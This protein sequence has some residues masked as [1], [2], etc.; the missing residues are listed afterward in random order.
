MRHWPPSRT[1]GLEEYLCAQ[2]CQSLHLY[3]DFVAR[4]PLVAKCPRWGQSP[5]L[6]QFDGRERP[7]WDLAHRFIAATAP[8]S[9]AWS[10]IEAATPGYF[11]AIAF[12]FHTSFVCNVIDV[13][14]IIVFDLSEFRRN[15]HSMWYAS[16]VF[17]SAAL[18]IF[19]QNFS[20]EMLSIAFAAVWSMR[21]SRCTASVSTTLCTWF[22]VVANGSNGL[23][24]FSDTYHFTVCCDPQNYQ[25]PTIAPVRSFSFCTTPSHCWWARTAYFR[26]FVDRNQSKHRSVSEV[27]RG[28]AAQVDTRPAEG[29][30]EMAA[31]RASFTWRCRNTKRCT[32]RRV[33]RSRE[34]GIKF[35]GTQ[36]LQHWRQT[37]AR[38]ATDDR[39]M[40]TRRWICDEECTVL[41]LRRRNRRAI[42]WW[43]VARQ[44]RL[45]L[46]QCRSQVL[47]ARKEQELMELR[48][49]RVWSWQDSQAETQHD[50][51]FVVRD[52]RSISR[53]F[54]NLYHIPALVNAL[55]GVYGHLSQNFCVRARRIRAAFQEGGNTLRPEI[56]AVVLIWRRLISV[57]SYSFWRQSIFFKAVEGLQ[58]LTWADF[59]SYTVFALCGLS[60]L[61]LYKE[62]NTQPLWKVKGLEQYTSWKVRVPDCVFREKWAKSDTDMFM[63]T[64]MYI[65]TYRCMYMCVYVS[66][67]FCVVSY[68]VVSCVARRCWL[69]GWV[70]CG[71]IDMSL[72]WWSLFLCRC[73]S[74][75][76]VIEK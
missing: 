23:C 17:A 72:S 61:Y 18:F 15:T 56:H 55:T 74:L 73:P 13:A 69:G 68:R 19:S 25:R 60:C 64:D 49:Q 76:V 27:L 48:Q 57:C 71:V 5:E 67:F 10:L 7:C 40:Y 75:C 54:R 24:R 42:V 45:G 66:L 1:R 26:K 4:E 6:S 32:S 52:A 65:Y 41:P 14:S 30:K 44:W 9:C 70:W 39:N 8:T 38:N 46:W 59:F 43:T 37:T 12:S 62:W 29:P 34:Q 31:T 20:R 33:F 3:N 50:P 21:F 51:H 35:L 22:R 63:N 36:L 53:K 2:Y 58:F 28:R 47:E 16:K 11:N